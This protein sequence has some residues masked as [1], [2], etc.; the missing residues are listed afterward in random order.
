MLFRLRVGLGNADCLENH[1]YS[2]MLNRTKCSF[3]SGPDKAIFSFTGENMS[4][5]EINILSTH[6]PSGPV[7]AKFWQFVIFSTLLCSINSDP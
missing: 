7:E 2:K 3:G 1:Q 4:S 6:A 5:K